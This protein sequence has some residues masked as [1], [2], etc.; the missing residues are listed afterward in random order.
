MDFGAEI[1]ELKGDIKTLQADVAEIK[2]TQPLLKNMFERNI[3]VQE[4]L[5][6]TLHEVEKSMVSINEKVDA[7]SKDITS[8]KEEMDETT[9]KINHKIN[10]VEDRIRTVDEE[11]KFNIRKF[12]QNYFPWI[13]VLVGIGAHFASKLFNF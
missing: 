12:F 3:T 5:T 11:G 1:K 6:E 7:Q 2:G 8:I 10:K 4:K 13:V 9:N